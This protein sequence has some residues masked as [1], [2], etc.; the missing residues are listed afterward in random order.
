MSNWC[1]LKEEYRDYDHT[2]TGDRYIE[3]LWAVGDAM[4]DR[5]EELEIIN[6]ELAIRYG[7]L[8]KKNIDSEEKLDAI[9]EKLRVMPEPLNYF[10][11]H[12]LVEWRD[13]M[14]EALGDE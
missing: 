3:K 12:E 13:K 14:L 9:R 7:S 11:C 8:I 10:D 1:N 2:K 6:I 5:I 4:R